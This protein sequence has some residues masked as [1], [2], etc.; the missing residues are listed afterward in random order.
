[1]IL[2]AVMSLIE[3]LYE[4][5]RIPF[6]QFLQSLLEQHNKSKPELYEFLYSHGYIIK[7][8][9]MYR[10]FNPNPAV[11]RMPDEDFI[12]L[13]A[14]FLQLSSEQKTALRNLWELKR[15]PKFCKTE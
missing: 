13:F 15:H 11:R 12:C 10:Y 4:I 8:T 6:P 14:D 2:V 5:Q 3:S 9:S 7:E 1:M